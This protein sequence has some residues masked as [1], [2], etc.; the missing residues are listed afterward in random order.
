MLHPITIERPIVFLTP[1]HKAHHRPLIEW[2]AEKLCSLTLPF[3][4]IYVYINI[5]I[6]RGAGD[7]QKYHI[8]K[9]GRLHLHDLKSS[10]ICAGRVQ[11]FWHFLR[12]WSVRTRRWIRKDVLH[13]LRRFVRLWYPTVRKKKEIIFKICFITKITKGYKKGRIWCF[14]EKSCKRSY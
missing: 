2:A 1:H 10:E 13:F 8:L 7:E 12:K 14:S 5:H 3:L 6:Y 9:K 11:Q 4:A